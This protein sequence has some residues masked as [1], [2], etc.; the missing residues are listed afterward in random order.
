MY[1]S[2]ENSNFPFSNQKIIKKRKIGKSYLDID[3]DTCTGIF[4]N[5]FLNFKIFLKV[6]IKLSAAIMKGYG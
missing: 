6:H 5:P 4:A 3:R 1:C 2:R